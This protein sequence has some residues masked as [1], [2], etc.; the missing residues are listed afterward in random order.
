MA[1][2]VLFDTPQSRLA[3]YPLSLTRPVCDLRHGILT[4][5]EWWK[6]VSGSDPFALSEPYQDEP[7]PESSCFICVDATVTPDEKCLRQILTLQPGVMLEDEHGMIAYATTNMPGYNQIPVWTEHS[8]QVPMQKRVTHISDIFKTNA[9]AIEAQFSSVTN[10]RDTKGV[11]ASNVVIGNNSL[12]LEAGAEMKACIINTVEGPV[13]IGKNALVME[14]TMIRGPVAICEGAVVKMG[15]KLYGGTT[16]G[17]YCTAGGEIKNTIL[18]GYSN[19]AHDGYLGDSVIGE[20]CNFGAGSS[21]SNVKNTGGEVSMWHQS[22]KSFAGVGQ[23]AG[24]VMGDY[25]RCAINSSFN[26]GTTIAVSCNVFNGAYPNKHLPSFSWGNHDRYEFEKACRDAA[27]WKKMKGKEFTAKDRLI[28][29]H[30]FENT[31]S[32]NSK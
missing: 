28:L 15:T 2:I 26:T 3:L 25:S 23:K 32:T 11:D 4:N 5:R 8:V 27:N 30:I 18:T 6:L 24:L 21:N 1:S 31:S 17:P 20:W 19:K 14:G 16:I 29:Q 9:M 7:L 10:D 12:F 22:T 13:Y